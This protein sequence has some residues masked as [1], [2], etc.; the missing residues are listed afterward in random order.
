LAGEDGGVESGEGF[1]GDGH[2]GLEGGASSLQL[3]EAVD[4]LSW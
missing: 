4:N 2:G 3:A 1:V